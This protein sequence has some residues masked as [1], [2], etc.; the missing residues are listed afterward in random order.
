[1]LGRG[2]DRGAAR[3]A[4]DACAAEL[5]GG[6]SVGPEALPALRLYLDVLEATLAAMDD[7]GDE[8]RRRLEAANARVDA[9]DRD[10]VRLDARVEIAAVALLAGHPDLVDRGAI[11]RGGATLGRRSDARLAAVRGLLALVDGDVDS[12]RAEAG[13]A[14]AASHPSD[15]E[16]GAFVRL[17]AAAAGPADAA[18]PRSDRAALAALAEEAQEKGDRHT[19]AAARGTLERLDADPRATVVTAGWS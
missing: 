15:W 1:L 3:R 10:P 12:A 7:R 2:F 17:L 6:E 5:D 13:R 14:R 16:M 19:E 8:A 11:R 9:V 18:T 4:A